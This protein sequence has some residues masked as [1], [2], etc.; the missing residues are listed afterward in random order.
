MTGAGESATLEHAQTS[1]KVGSLTGSANGSLDGS[2]GTEGLVTKKGSYVVGVPSDTVILGS[3]DPDL[4]R[5]IL[6]DHL[7]QFRSCYQRELER[8]SSGFSGVVPLDF[9]IG[10]SGHVTRAG[11]SSSSDVP[12]PV[13]GCVLNVLRGIKFPEPMGGGEVQVKQPMNFRT[14][15]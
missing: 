12:K 3:M 15:Q 5:R 10:A 14:M 9:M 8:A 13:V 7:P 2:I 1:G 11:V 6:M 4:I